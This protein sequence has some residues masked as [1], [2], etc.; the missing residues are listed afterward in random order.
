[1]PFLFRK[2]IIFTG[3]DIFWFGWFVSRRTQTTTEQISMK[4]GWRMGVSPEWTTLTSG[5]DPDKGTD[6]NP[7][8]P[9]FFSVANFDICFL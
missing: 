6:T 7:F 3:E 1:M 8:F 2:Y 4:R 5:V 9:T